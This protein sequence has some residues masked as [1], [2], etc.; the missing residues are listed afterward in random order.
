M[1]G[2][3]TAFLKYNH[4]ESSYAFPIMDM[5]SSHAKPPFD[6]SCSRR[7]GCLIMSLQDIYTILFFKVR[8]SSA[9]R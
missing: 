2:D 7:A 1:G 6:I 5:L 8:G 4:G 9:A 3:G